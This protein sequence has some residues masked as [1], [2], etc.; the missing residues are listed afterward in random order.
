[1]ALTLQERLTDAHQRAMRLYLRRQD[2]EA[3]KQ[4]LAQ[5]AQAID[6]ALVRTDGE[7]VVLE[8][9]IAEEASRGE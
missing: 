2:V 3:Q 8:S 4:Q 6:V 1:M 5:Q 7:I 9:L